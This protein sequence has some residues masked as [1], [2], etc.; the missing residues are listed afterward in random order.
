MFQFFGDIKDLVGLAIFAAVIIG[1]V[2]IARKDK[3]GK[4]GSNSNNTGASQ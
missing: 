3:N 1:G 2:M 4:G